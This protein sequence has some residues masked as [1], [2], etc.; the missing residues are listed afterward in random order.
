MPEPEIKA[1]DSSEVTKYVSARRHSHD[2]WHS[3]PDCCRLKDCSG[4][5]EASAS[6]IVFHEMTACDYCTGARYE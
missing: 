5:R 4:V 2:V 1:A 3:D 6:L